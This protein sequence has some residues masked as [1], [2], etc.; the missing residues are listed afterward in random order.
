MS[1]TGYDIYIVGLGIVSYLQITQEVIDTLKI[2]NKVFFLH[3]ETG[4]LQQYLESLCPDVINIYSSYEEGACRNEAYSEMIDTVL[5][6]GEDHAPVALALYGHPAVFVTPT[7]V[8]SEVAPSR[9]LAVKVRPG[10]SALDCILVD[11]KI[12]PSRGLL[13][14][15]ANEMLLS[16][17]TLLPD[18]AC[19]IWQPGT[20]ESEIFTFRQNKPERFDRLKNYLLQF[21]PESH[22]VFIITCAMNPLVKPKISTVTIGNV[23]QENLQ[24]HAGATLYIPPSVSRPVADEAFNELLSSKEHL[25]APGSIPRSLLRTFNFEIWKLKCLGACPEDLY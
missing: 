3:Q 10:I 2:C 7:E 20:V 15:E 6:A 19:L 1:R 9:G 21:Y 5:R 25:I 4:L 12:D 22:E 11:L 17:R 14:F 13:M 23:E 24:L 8:I 16:R 18:V